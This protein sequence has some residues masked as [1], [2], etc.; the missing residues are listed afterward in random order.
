MQRGLFMQVYELTG[1]TVLL[2]RGRVMGSSAISGQVSVQR[3]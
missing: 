3:R 1:D 2:Q